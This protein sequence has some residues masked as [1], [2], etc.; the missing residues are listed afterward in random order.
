LTTLKPSFRRQY[1]ILWY[2]TWVPLILFTFKSI[3]GEAFVN[4]AAFAYVGGSVLAGIAVST[5][6]NWIKISQIAVSLIIAVVFYH[7]SSFQQVL[8]N[9]PTKKNTPYARTDG[10]RELTQQAVKLAEQHPAAFVASN[11]RTINAYFSFYL[12]DSISRL[13]TLNPDNHVSNHYELFYLLQDTER[14]VLWFS[15]KALTQHPIDPS[16]PVPILLTKL[17]QPVYET[18]NRNLWVYVIE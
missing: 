4:W 6:K 18:F 15:E 11:S 1:P 16:R 2:L 8:N 3:Q 7:F 17:N 10:W 9:Q 14:P 12:P 13:R 5:L